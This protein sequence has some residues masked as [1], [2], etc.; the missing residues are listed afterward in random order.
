MDHEPAWLIY[1]DMNECTTAAEVHKIGQIKRN[2]LTNTTKQ[3]ETV[4]F[5]ESVRVSLLPC[6]SSYW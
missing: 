6:A 5:V 4:I 3:K 1:N 2:V